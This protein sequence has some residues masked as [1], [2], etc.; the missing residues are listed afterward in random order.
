[1][2]MRTVFKITW[3]C[4]LCTLNMLVDKWRFFFPLS[5]INLGKSLCACAE[6]LLYRKN[7]TRYNKCWSRGDSF[8][9]IQKVRENLFYDESVIFVLESRLWIYLHAQ[10]VLDIAKI[11]TLYIRYTI[12]WSVAILFFL[13]RKVRKN[14]YDESMYA[15]SVL[16]ITKI[17]AMPLDSPYVDQC[18]YDIKP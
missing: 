6:C 14:L 3:K 8:F 4:R 17:S 7:F 9:L 16:D 1:M 2:C 11:S 5:K 10:S 12:C 18:P 13:I 15:Q